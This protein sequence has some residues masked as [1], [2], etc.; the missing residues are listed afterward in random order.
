MIKN[1]QDDNRRWQRKPEKRPDDIL[2]GALSE[3]RARGF[4]RARIEDIAGHAGLSKGAVY[5]YFDS[6]EAMLKALVRRSV[7]SVAD[8]LKGMADH[9]ATSSSGK[10]N[11]KAADIL[12]TML[13][14]AANRLTDPQTASIPLL[15]IAEAGNFPDLVEYYR[16]EVIETV[17][18]A[19]SDVISFGV[20]SG[21]FRP[22]DCH[23]AARSLLGVMMLQIIWNGVFV[24][25]DEIPIPAEKL[26]MSHLD[27]FL[28]GAR[29][30][31]EGFL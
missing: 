5:L 1:K 28:G 16:S 26:I 14:L 3:F 18:N 4:A 19:V 27:L 7:K 11:V 15:V 9:M 23:L 31:K 13:L 29:P 22:L 24:R 21:E 8:T 6:K 17:M 20:N 25:P 30:R 10:Q 12:L 2:D